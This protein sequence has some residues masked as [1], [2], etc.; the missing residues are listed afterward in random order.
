M[1]GADERGGQSVPLHLEGSLEIEQ[2][3]PIQAGLRIRDENNRIRLSR[4]KKRSSDISLKNRT[5]DPNVK[6]KKKKKS[7]TNKK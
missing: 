3:R 7:E 6:D 1:E 5:M 4:K 2:R